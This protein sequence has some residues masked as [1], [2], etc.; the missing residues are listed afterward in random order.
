MR[1]VPSDIFAAERRRV[2]SKSRTMT[3]MAVLATLLAMPMKESLAANGAFAGTHDTPSGVSF[4]QSEMTDTITINAPTATITWTPTDDAAGAGAINFLPTGSTVNFV[5]DSGLQ[6]YTVLNR[7]VPGGDAAG[8]SVALNGT[9]TSDTRGNIWFYSPNGLL[10]GANAHIDVGGLLLT[11]VDGGIAGVNQFTSNENLSLSGAKVRVDSTDVK[12]GNYVA[13]I[14][15]V[16]EQGGSITSDGSVAYVAARAAEMTVSNG[17]FDITVPFQDTMPGGE[18]IDFLGQG[19]TTVNVLGEG[20]TRRI[21]LVGVPKNNAMTMLLGG[22]T[23][24]FAVAQGVEIT[25]TGIVLSGGRN[26][27]GE[28][29]EGPG[30]FA[31]S[32][33]AGTGT[34][35]VEGTTFN[36]PVFIG[37]SQDL[38]IS[39][40]TF[41]ADVFVEADG[42]IVTLATNSGNLTFNENVMV[43]V[44]NFGTD[45][46]GFGGDVALSATSGVLTFAKS[47]DI[48]ASGYS[49]AGTGFGGNITVT[50]AG[51]GSE[52]KFATLGGTTQLS[53]NGGGD[54]GVA[55][56]ISFNASAGGTISFLDTLSASAAGSGNLY[57]GTGG[58]IDVNASGTNSAVTFAGNATLSALGSGG[59]Y[60]GTGQGGLIRIGASSGGSVNYSGG[61]LLASATG[62]GGIGVEGDGGNGS[63][64]VI[65]VTATNGIISGTG[66][67]ILSA[68]SIGGDGL[69]AGGT[70][71]ATAPDPDQ[72]F[73]GHGAIYVDALNGGSIVSA[74]GATLQAF[75]AGGRGA[76]GGNSGDGRGGLVALSSNGGGTIELRGTTTAYADGQIR[77]DDSGPSIDF[78]PGVSGGTGGGNG[79]GGTISL[80]AG[81]DGST[82]EIYSLSAYARGTGGARGDGS[83]GT[84][85]GGFFDTNVVNAGA[86]NF[87]NYDQ[88]SQTGSGSLLINLTGRGGDSGSGMGGEG[89][90]GEAFLGT[91]VGGGALRFDAATITADGFGGSNTTATTNGGT[92]TG[93]KVVIEARRSG[94]SV[95]GSTVTLNANGTG[96]TG[97]DDAQGGTGVGGLASFSTGLP[98]RSV[99]GGELTISN[100]ATANA[101]GKGGDGGYGGAGYGGAPGETGTFGA[102]ADAFTGAANFNGFGLELNANGEGGQGIA[103]D[104]FG[105]TGG[106]GHGGYAEFY[107]YSISNF[108][109]TSS[110]VGATN[111]AIHVNGLGGSGNTDRAQTS[112]V[113]G[114]R[115]G[116]GF[117]GT[118]FVG[119]D[120]GT[121]HFQVSGAAGLQAYAV[122]GTGGIGT[123]DIEEIGDID[124]GDGGQGGSAEGG[125]IQ[126]GLFSGDA[127]AGTSGQ[128]QFGILD[129][130]VHA[131][132]GLGGEAAGGS[133]SGINGVAGS[134]GNAIG[135]YA[136][137]VAAGASVG[138][139]NLLNVNARAEAGGSGLDADA[140]ASGSAGFARGG[141]LEIISAYRVNGSTPVE[142]TF[143]SFV[144]GD[145]NVS[146]T[147][148]SL[149][150]SADVSGIGAAGVGTPNVKAGRFEIRTN[151]GDITINNASIQAF[152]DP[153]PLQMNSDGDPI[154]GTGPSIV[155][156]NNG[157][158]AF[159][160]FYLTTDPNPTATNLVVFSTMGGNTLTAV[161]CSVNGENCVG[162]DTGNQSPP[163]PPPPPPEGPPPLVF[164]SN[165]PPSGTVGT[166][167]SNY[168]PV[169][170]GTS[171][172]TY[173]IASGSLPPGLT[174]NETTGE[175]SG[176][177]TQEGSYTFSVMVTDSEGMMA[178]QGYSFSINPSQVN[179]SPPPPVSPPPPISPP[180]PP[181]VSP[182]PPPP[183]DPVSPPPP[184]PVD[185][186]SPP[187]PPVDP[188]SP[189]PPPPVDPVSPP[190][191]IEDPEVV[192]T[193]TMETTKIT[194]SIQASLTG[195]R[196]AGGSVGGGGNAGGGGSG[197]GGSS[198]GSG[199]GGSGSGSGSGDSGAGPAA[200]S[201]AGGADD[202]A[203]TGADEGG[204]DDGSNEESGGSSG[205]SG[206]AVG[207][208]NVLIDTSRVGTGP[209]QIDT[210]IAGGG[211]SSLWSG[212]DGLGDTGGDGPGG[213]Q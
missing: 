144:I 88:Q 24:G 61:F 6:S 116:D 94:G 194:S 29:I 138:V 183:V 114:G 98:D 109:D 15:P 165:P 104:V 89:K 190:P 129:L 102:L 150:L 34:V 97:G 187:P 70:G 163:P 78:T 136:R 40:G 9:I 107:A 10:V 37:S 105:G 123:N 1:S 178:S 151:G 209:Q 199:S 17:L 51:Q 23:L 181:P 202:G 62:I 38:T 170:G 12:A 21:Y 200:A 172:Y 177:P 160:N 140:V 191:V 196:V 106:D 103:S 99:E 145:G 30:R 68:D 56:D 189:P 3:S 76:N 39:G 43:D 74:G 82:L 5:G 158:I 157:D 81:G 193:V 113:D 72:E 20:Q 212:A 188:V 14:A 213:N 48:D 31:T 175:V 86:V 100:K 128:V 92:G 171:P 186:V 147:P 33:G 149:T 184:P 28:A 118:I 211:N 154:F 60:A 27:N 79:Q 67:L 210:P 80:L 139:N 32:D 13:I 155:A 73:D 197:G 25:D 205:G 121:G 112:G 63:G 174:L 95:T 203:G 75:G 168:V 127:T 59:D 4:S 119:A 169:S 26:V 46:D 93:G 159:G 7:I 162:V 2:K 120:A 77:D 91:A 50:A 85:T 142:G 52:V 153:V 192:E 130:D 66:Q 111:L 44:S 101:N 42:H 180:P 22:A 122:G 207:G 134:G 58:I 83:G 57:D 198:G 164:D 41:N 87:L 141:V 161:N 204:D 124:G 54:H 143:G 132:G 65:R 166:S 49:S 64:G 173:T 179:P 71:Q 18:S 135:G 146:P 110:T 185:P 55:G 47:L 182:P 11:T 133:G 69:G 148:G 108:A 208:A 152:G 96:G 19:Q 36:A 167:Y 35:T 126:A 131:R 195:T 137:M 45:G 8:R 84:G 156:A 16:I 90:G 176:T 125:F 206:N 201:S 115:G 53:V 117:G